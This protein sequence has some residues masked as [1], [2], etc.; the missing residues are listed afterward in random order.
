MKIVGLTG[1]IGSG[2]STI[3]KWFSEK[4]IPVYDSDT[5]AKKLMNEN[6]QIREHLLG[7]FGPE[8]YVNDAL[9]RKHIASQVF[10]DKD[11]LEKLN[12]IVHPVVAQDFRN[13]AQEQI[14]PFVVKE[15][16][17]LFE[18]GAYKD[19]D[20]VVSVVSNEELRI[21]RVMARDGSSREEVRSRVQNQWTDELR[22]VNS[23]F[24]IRN[25]S[26]L[27]DLKQEFEKVY[28]KLM[29]KAS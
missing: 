21:Q 18:S 10:E 12:Q 4:Q 26:T 17:I 15:A 23:D 9:N 6:P 3:A 16:A 7:L 20:L 5:E 25:N 8:A 24:I 14:A 29:K 11:L 27:E 1:G 2:K 28:L 13:W 22:V 19:C